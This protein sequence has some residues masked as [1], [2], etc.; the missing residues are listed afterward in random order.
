[1]QE[2][3]KFASRF[4]GKGLNGGEDRFGCCIVVQ[5]RRCS[6]SAGGASIFESSE[7]R[8][9]TDEE[10]TFGAGGLS[11]RS[12]ASQAQRR[13]FHR[14]GPEYKGPEGKSAI[15]VPLQDFNSSRGY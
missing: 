10:W 13:A 7:F 14:S 9:A 8:R 6:V 5:E 15:Y 3:G 12:P 2:R 1:M 11:S 4:G